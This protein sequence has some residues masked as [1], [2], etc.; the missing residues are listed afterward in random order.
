MTTSLWR[1]RNWWYDQ[2]SSTII[3]RTSFNSWCQRSFHTYCLSSRRQKESQRSLWTFWCRPSVTSSEC[4]WVGEGFCCGTLS[5]RY[6]L[7]M[8]IVIYFVVVQCLLVYGLS[9]AFPVH[10][11]HVTRVSSSQGADAR[12]RTGSLRSWW[13]STETGTPWFSPRFTQCTNYSPGFVIFPAITAVCIGML[14][15]GEQNYTI[16]SK[17]WRWACYQPCAKSQIF[18]RKQRKWRKLGLTQIFPRNNNSFRSHV[19]LWTLFTETTKKSKSASGYIK[20]IYI[21]TQIRNKY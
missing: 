16:W 7:F 15:G 21:L 14:F 19:L 20:Q 6:A 12:T 18:F 4:W 17:I 8:S 2:W 9:L 1:W 5:G 3:T 13:T 10:F 11:N